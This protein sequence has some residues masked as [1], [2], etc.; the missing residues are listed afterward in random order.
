MIKS[1]NH[2]ILI[3]ILTCF[4]AGCVSNGG[5]E[6]ISGSIDDGAEETIPFIDNNK[7]E[8]L[9]FDFMTKE[10]FINYIENN[11]VG[12]TLNDF[13]GIDIDDFIR[14]EFFSVD[15]ISSYNLVVALEGYLQKLEDDRLMAYL[16]KE[17]VSV[18]S[19]DEEYKEFLGKF[20][21]S[22]DG[23]I[24]SSG[25]E[26]DFINWYRI[27]WKESDG[28]NRTEYMRI[29]QTKYLERYGTRCTDAGVYLLQIQW[30]SSGLGY[31]DPLFYN[32]N[33]KYFYAGG[34]F[35][36]GIQFTEME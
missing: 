17:L 19:T 36:W 23:K 22:I 16:A 12:V 15:N 2:L 6:T 9:D 21:S 24:V 20:I 29:G 14:R 8:V 35:E 13:E 10:E 3:L 32:K 1:K 4:A 30:D 27:S 26:N 28:E 18:D 34:K 7:E 33:Q 25:I 5:D 11:E 31:E